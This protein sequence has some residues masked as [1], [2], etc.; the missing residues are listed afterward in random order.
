MRKP[1]L[2]TQILAVNALLLCAAVPAAIA[3]SKLDTSYGAPDQMLLIIAAI[4]A[5]VLVNGIVLRR[6]LWP[7]EHLI[8]VMEK[9]DLQTPGARVE[10]PEAD[11]SDVV[12]L[13]EAFNRMLE[14]LEAERQATGGAVLHAQEDERARIARDLHDE[15]NQSLT[16]LLLRI[17][18]A[19]QHAPPELQAELRET[20][21][22]ATQAMDEL[23]SLARELRPSALDD[24]GLTAALRSQMSRFSSETGI[25]VSLRSDNCLDE[26]GEDEQI[27]VYR[28]VQESLSNI[29]RHSNAKHVE[30]AIGSDRSVRVTDDGD[31]FDLSAVQGH[32]LVGMRERARLAGASVE[33]HSKVGVGTTIELHLATGPPFAGRR[34]RRMSRE[35]SDVEAA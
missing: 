23:L 22:L 32:G 27:V 35:Q 13:H 8:E 21:A 30:V 20:K 17:E 33:V 6:R 10:L 19:A 24:H 26:L 29:V 9:I 4:L 3:A 5:T 28:T 12:R 14:R 7:L 15:A 25:A 34:P 11:T 18:A 16:G 1:S 2:L 31:G